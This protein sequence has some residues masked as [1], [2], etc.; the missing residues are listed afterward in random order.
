MTN[1]LVVTFDDPEHK[2]IGLSITH[3]ANTV[4]IVPSYPGRPMHD[5]INALDPRSGS[6]QQIVTWDEEPVQ[7]DMEFTYNQDGVRM[8][9]REYPDHRRSCDTGKE[10]FVVTGSYEQ[11]CLPFW[12]ALRSLQG[13]FPPEE[14]DQRCGGF[15]SHELDKLTEA[16]KNSKDLNIL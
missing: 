12:R 7:C 3:G 11:I 13:R 10:T 5:L 9:I 2:W 6:Q 8:T 1:K 14:L 15:P 16:I 4:D